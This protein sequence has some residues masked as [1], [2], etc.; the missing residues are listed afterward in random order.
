M[1]P[2]VLTGCGG[3]RL[4]GWLAW[5][6]QLEPS[7]EES[8]G[9]DRSWPVPAIG[10]ER[11]IVGVR[12]MNWIAEVP[13]EAGISRVLPRDAREAVVHVAV[14]VGVASVGIW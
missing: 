7:T 12:W 2:L 3:I 5:G 6:G 9:I 4:G 11:W 10:D 13:M 8:R 14:W 1:M